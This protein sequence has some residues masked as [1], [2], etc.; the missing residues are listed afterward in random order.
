MEFI[1]SDEIR[2]NLFDSCA[3]LDLRT[4]ST[5]STTQEANGGNPGYSM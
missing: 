5:I 4:I 1:C 2:I 3:W